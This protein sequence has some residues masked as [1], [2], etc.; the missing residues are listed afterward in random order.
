MDWAEK[1]ASDLVS[2]FR[3]AFRDDATGWA[4]S[5]VNAIAGELRG[6]AAETH[7]DVMKV[8]DRAVSEISMQRRR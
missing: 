8:L 4:D 6:V 3:A 7:G 5:L 2:Q 1:K